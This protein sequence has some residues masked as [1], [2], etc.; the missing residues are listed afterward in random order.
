MNIT[1]NHI[2]TRL[3]WKT[4]IQSYSNTG[5]LCHI[6]KYRHLRVD[7]F[8]LRPCKYKAETQHNSLTSTL[9]LGK[10]IP[11]LSLQCSFP[12]VLGKC[13]YLQSKKESYIWQEELIKP[14]VFVKIQNQSWNHISK[15]Y[16]FNHGHS[17]LFLARTQINTLLI[18]HST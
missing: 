16:F 13:L 18:N 5:Y 17:N 1:W 11:L 9:W 6:N 2:Q 7:N 12:Y 4:K 8:F 14:L 15:Q 10:K 3:R